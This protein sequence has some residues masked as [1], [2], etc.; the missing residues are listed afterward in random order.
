[1]NLPSLGH[2]I[3]GGRYRLVR[4]TYDTSGASSVVELGRSLPLEAH[5]DRL[6]KLGTDSH[7]EAFNV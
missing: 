6:E 4:V 7:D 1:M 5:L 2:S 3:S